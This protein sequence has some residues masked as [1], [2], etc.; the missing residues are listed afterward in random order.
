MRSVATSECVRR[1]ASLRAVSVEPDILYAPREP[2]LR[3]SFGARHA[4]PKVV[5][6]QRLSSLI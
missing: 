4:V 3:I 5:S 2:R 6:V 1:D